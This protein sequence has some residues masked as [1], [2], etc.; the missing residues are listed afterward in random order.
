MSDSRANPDDLL[1]AIRREELASSTSQLRIFLGMSAGVGKTYAMLNAAHRKL[2][3]GFDV[4]I[5]V[6]ETHGRVETAALLGGLEVIPRKKIEYKGTVLEEMDV[7]AILKRKPEVVI[8]DE[9]AHTNVPGGRHQKRYQDILELLDAGIDVYSALNVQ[10][11]ESRKE[12]VES[13]TQVIIRET[14]PDS[15]I[16]RANQVELVD[17]SPAELL[18]RLKEGKVYLGDKAERAQQNF[19]KEDRL[20]ALR[21]IALRLTAER[22]DQ[23][24]QKFS[25]VYKDRSPWQTNERLMVAV[26][27]SPYSEKLIRATRR[28]AYNLEAP[29]IAVHIDTG[30]FLSN[31]DQLQLTKNLNLARELK[32]EVI[33][34]TE[35][36][37]PEALKR[38]ARQ[39][40]VTQILV[41]RPTKRWFRDRFEGGS[42]LDRL[43]RE[44]LE[45]DIHVLSQ[46]GRRYEPQ[47][48]KRWM[49]YFQF[50]SQPVQY[51]NTLWFLG[52]TTLLAEALNPIIEYRS[53]GFL[54]LSSVLIVGAMGSMGTVVFSAVLS[55]L[56]WNFFFIPPRFTFIIR[57]SEDV[58]MC[59]SFIV[60]AIIMGFLTNRIRLHE[61]IIRDREERTNVLYEVLRDITT[62]Q[63]KADFLSKVVDRVGR[64]LD[65]TCG[66]FLADQSGQLKF[67]QSER[68]FF[69]IDKKAQAVAVWAFQSAK[70]AGWSTETL[71]EAA[72]LYLPL[73]GSVSTVG[74]FV[75]QPR[76]NRRLNLEQQTLLESICKQLG[77]SLETHSIEK[78]LRESKRLEESERLHQTLLNSISHEMRTPLT[79]ILGSASALANENAASDPKFVKLA[80][81]QL[82]DAGERLNRV[83]ENLLDMSRLNSGVLAIKQDWHDVNDL[84]RLVVA[85]S[86][87]LLAQHKLEIKLGKDLPLVKMDFRFME[88]ALANLVVNA[89]LYSPINT[90]IIISA[91]IEDKSLR[92]SVE[93][94]GPG[95]PEDA[96]EKVLEKFYRIPGTPTGGTGLGLSIVKSIAEA[97]RGHVLVA[98]APN[99][100]GG[101]LF[102]IVL[103]LTEELPDVPEVSVKDR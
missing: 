92:I 36:D 37:I 48:R 103:P 17:I 51:W 63:G 29:W 16:E 54:F 65:A 64:L 96:R 57:A 80:A 2:A 87:K 14:V 13:I 1:E 69:P 93:D 45:V 18:K 19:F 28:I 47:S 7:D 46:Q 32:A 24:L 101:A 88:H 94:E 77:V 3:D 100:S 50:S 95:I 42:L 81:Q 86:E 31:E 52:A 53:I 4:V 6:A 27:H 84:I 60:V 34:T 99:G 21:E 35:T 85:K 23:D 33:T 83:I 40:N 9:M 90:T 91:F 15:L 98:S 58:A 62:S 44:S 71:G 55:V 78:R 43:V 67:D 76:T 66:V 70:P 25:T 8:V 72:S 26:S 56:F 75:F 97:H 12:S 79:A 49:G 89:A 73:V 39:K 41:G 61:R 38:L 30:V 68:Y 22:V 5:G 59:V 20:T 74:I 102:T 10:H 11:L 82:I